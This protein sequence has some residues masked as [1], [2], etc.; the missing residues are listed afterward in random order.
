MLDQ[1][2][3]SIAFTSR[4]GDGVVD[5]LTEVLLGLRLDGVEYGRCVMRKP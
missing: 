3:D 1:T 4:T 2:S 5:T